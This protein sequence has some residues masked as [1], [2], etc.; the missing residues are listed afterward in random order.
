ML[1]AM[2]EQRPVAP[3]IELLAQSSTVA[4]DDTFAMRL[5]VDGL[6]LA[7]LTLDVTLFGALEPGAVTTDPT[8]PPLAERQLD[9]FAGFFVEPTGVVAVR[10]PVGGADAGPSRFSLP[11]PGVYPVR[12]RLGDATGTTVD[13]STTMIRLPDDAL[14]TTASI[15]VALVVEVGADTGL[16]VSSASALAEQN[17]NVPLT[18]ILGRETVGDLATDTGAADALVSALGGRPVAVE[19][20]TAL[21]PSA[22]VA[23]GLDGLFRSS[24]TAAF[25][26]GEALGLAVDHSAIVVD[27]PLTADGAELLVD[28]GITTALF[29]T[30]L[31][32]DQ[33]SVPA[34][35]WPSTTGW[36]ATSTDPLLVV[37]PDG[38][39]PAQTLRGGQS[40]THRA[41]ELL[42]L[43]ASRD[44]VGDVGVV[45]AGFQDVNDPVATLS[46]LLE[47]ME[48]T[49]LFR[50]QPLTADAVGGLGAM[51]IV[52]TV[53]DSRQDLTPLTDQLDRL[54]QRLLTYTSF[55]LDGS[56]TPGQYRD[57]LRRAFA[58]DLS[59]AERASELDRLES[60]LEAAL[61]VITLSGNQSVTL[62]ARSA[63]LPLAVNNRAEGARRV[64]IQ[65]SSDK[66]TVADPS[67]IVTVPPGASVIE[68]DVETRSLG[69]SPVSV[70]LL[71]PDGAQVLTTTRFQVRSTAIPGL[72][73]L[74]S[75]IGLALLGAWWYVS[76]RRSRSSH[77]SRSDRRRH[78]DAP[79]GRKGATEDTVFAD[80]DPVAAGGS[81]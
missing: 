76:I 70:S 13:I 12:L 28:M 39:W 74:L 17:P 27:E 4:V 67:Q 3:S 78:R 47:A 8:D 9:A 45:L 7:T 40:S 38:S 22:L 56:R 6:D 61:G 63:P 72:G 62:A 14:P 41:Q 80:R 24:T 66:I 43:L 73:L 10:L 51:S 25:E 60:D 5:Q 48:A 65:L 2:A 81:V 64:R 44:S 35:R 26:Q 46:L 32:T 54:D 37:D 19:T 31:F 71:T 50:L 29:T 21:D 36:L 79:Q 15:P 52:G 57:D 18:V 23:I 68:L 77:P 33:R 42:A 55:H 53:P 75:A 30:A 16:S 1:T 58:I 11:S 20:D 34:T 69:A 59:S 49:T